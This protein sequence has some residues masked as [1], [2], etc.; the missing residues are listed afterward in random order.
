[1]KEASVVRPL[2]SQNTTGYV[3][4]ASLSDLFQKS[5]TTGRCWL[6]PPMHQAHCSQDIQMASCALVGWFHFFASLRHFQGRQEQHLRSHS[7]HEIFN[8]TLL[9]CYFR[10]LQQT[11]LQ[12]HYIRKGKVVIE[13]GP[14][15]PVPIRAHLTSCRGG[16]ATPALPDPVCCY[17]WQR[18]I[19]R[20]AWPKGWGHVW[21]HVKLV[22]PVQGKKVWQHSYQSHHLHSYERLFCNTICLTV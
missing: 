15:A 22:P 11:V 3:A 2:N 14:A 21:H 13:V 16:P 5:Q 7:S 20:G 1:M 12:F 6:E 9:F 8:H 4:K 18:H 19:T 10:L 17:F